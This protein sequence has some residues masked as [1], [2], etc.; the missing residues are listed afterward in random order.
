MAVANTFPV[1]QRVQP[2]VKHRLHLHLPVHLRPASRI[3][4]DLQTDGGLRA[5]EARRNVRLA[6]ADVRLHAQRVVAE[7]GQH[8]ARRKERR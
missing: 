7:P 4:G 6:E 3:G 1:F 2:F 8:G 5:G